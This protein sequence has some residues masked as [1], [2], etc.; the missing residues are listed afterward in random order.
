MDADVKGIDRSVQRT[1]Y[2]NQDNSMQ[3]ASSMASKKPSMHNQSV[4]QRPEMVDR[5]IKKSTISYKD[6]GV[7]QIG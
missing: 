4:M 2:F 5:S 7:Q 3:Y 6:E 1:V